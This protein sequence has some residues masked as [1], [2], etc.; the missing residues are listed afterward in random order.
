MRSINI[1]TNKKLIVTIILLFGILNVKFQCD[2]GY[3]GIAPEIK[4]EFKERVRISPYNLDY[5]VGDTIWLLVDIPDKKLF[6]EKTNTKIFFDSASFTSIAQVDLLYNNPF[7][8][9]GP[10]AAFVFPAGVSAYRGNGVAQTYSNI[11]Y[12]CSSSTGYKLLTGIVLIEKGVFGISFF[13]T[14]IQKC[15][16]GNFQNSKLSYVFDVNDTHKQFYQQLPFSAIGKKQ[17]DFVLERLDKKTMV[18]VNVR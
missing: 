11:N 8:G 17:D 9:T 12:G 16:T 14:A 7:I 10:F 6:D 1:M 13:N 3:D 5:K 4:Y 15:F 18:V 2:K